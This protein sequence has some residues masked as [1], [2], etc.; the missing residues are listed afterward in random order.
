MLEFFVPYCA[1]HS[2]GQGIVGGI[3]ADDSTQISLFS[4]E[5]T[6]TQLAVSGQA[7]TVT[8]GAGWFADRID[9][10]DLAYTIAKGVAASGFRGV[11]SGNL[12]KGA[13]LRFDNSLQFSP[14]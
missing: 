13:V 11:A 3:R 14:G 5:K 12:Y 9:K 6:G 10:A 4:G 1:S 7:D 8:G 2:V